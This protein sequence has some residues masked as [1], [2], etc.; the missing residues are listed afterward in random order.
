MAK[1]KEYINIGEVKV[2]AELIRIIPRQT[3]TFSRKFILI[4]PWR[5]TTFEKRRRLKTTNK[6]KLTIKQINKMTIN[7][8]QI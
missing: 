6:V 3:N 1:P 5:E 8:F 2:E 4:M 7:Q